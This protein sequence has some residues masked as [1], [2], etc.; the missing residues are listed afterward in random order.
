[1]TNKQPTQCEYIVRYMREFGSITTFEAFVELGITRLGARISE[2][3]KSGMK[4]KGVTETS[5]NRF[6]KNVSYMRYYLTERGNDLSQN[7]ECSQRR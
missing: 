6:G 1:M 5:K 2:M 3:R 7:A 4:I